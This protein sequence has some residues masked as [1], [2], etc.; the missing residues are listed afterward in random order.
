MKFDNLYAAWVVVATHA[1]VMHVSEEFAVLKTAWT[2][3]LL[4]GVVVGAVVMLVRRG[5]A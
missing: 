2:L 3:T 4:V 5:K 1:L